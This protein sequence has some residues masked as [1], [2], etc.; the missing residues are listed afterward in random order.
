MLTG[1]VTTVSDLT[2]SDKP[3][4]PRIE[5][6]ALETLNEVLLTLKLERAVILLHDRD[7]WKVGCAHE[8]PTERFWTTAPISQT[9]L[10]TAILKKEP[11]FLVDAMETPEYASQAS[12]VIS[13]MRSVASVPVLDQYGEVMAVVYA[14]HLV[15]KNAF[16]LAELETLKELTK[17]FGKKLLLEDWDDFG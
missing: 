8:I 4:A 14:D 2:I 1:E 15:Q 6:I 16:G 11:L 5:E 7:G 9:I 13:G 12:V 10:R 17:E 3:L